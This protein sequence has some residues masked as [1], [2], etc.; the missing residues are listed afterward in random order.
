MQQAG[1]SQLLAQSGATSVS[2]KCPCPVK[3]SRQR[4]VSLRAQAKEVTLLDYGAGNVR[5]VRNAI[6]RL[7]YA[8]KDVRDPVLA[9][10]AVLSMFFLCAR[11]TMCTQGT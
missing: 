2:G 3:P 4:C 11:S 6:T 9:A 10:G 7:G 5:S 1:G 8:I